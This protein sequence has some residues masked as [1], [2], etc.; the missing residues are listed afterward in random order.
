MYSVE[1]LKS[2]IGVEIIHQGQSQTVTEVTSD[3]I[4]LLLFD[5]PISNVYKLSN[6]SKNFKEDLNYRVF[7]SDDS[8]ETISVAEFLNNAAT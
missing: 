4:T 8:D 2:L 1:Q 7:V 5:K 3:S 6:I